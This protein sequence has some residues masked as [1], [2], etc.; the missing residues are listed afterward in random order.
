MTKRLP[1]LFESGI[2][3][4]PI[5]GSP[6]VEFLDFQSPSRRF[7]RLFGRCHG[8]GEATAIH[9]FFVEMQL[10]GTGVEVVT[11]QAGA[12]PHA[13][14]FNGQRLSGISY[15]EAKTM[16]LTELSRQMNDLMAAQPVDPSW[17]YPPKDDS[18][19]EMLKA[20][21]KERGIK[22]DDVP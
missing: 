4:C 15:D 19:L 12:L 16:S 1:P 17:A 2:F 13:M 7:F 18:L 3:G 11:G 5:C 20:S 9:E 6:I 8:L 22:P 10:A 21:L 14:S